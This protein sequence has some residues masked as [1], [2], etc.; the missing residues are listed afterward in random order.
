M[1]L[2]EAQKLE[3]ANIFATAKD[4][5][6][7]DRKLRAI[8]ITSASEIAEANNLIYAIATNKP[9]PKSNG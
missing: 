2:T 7:Y 8:G 5:A 3:V 9:V 4:E 1:V 6:D